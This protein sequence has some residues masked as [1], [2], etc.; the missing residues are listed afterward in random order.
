[1]IELILKFNL[2]NGGN[3]KGFSRKI[4]V[5]AALNI[6]EACQ[7]PYLSTEPLFERNMISTNE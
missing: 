2:V 4:R 7:S 5:M 3:F 6:S 1:M